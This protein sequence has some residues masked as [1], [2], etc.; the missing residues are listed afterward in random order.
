MGFSFGYLHHLIDGLG[1]N[2]EKGFSRRRYYGSL[3]REVMCLAFEGE[4]G[5]MMDL[6]KKIQRET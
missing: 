3:I 2:K 6:G 5:K 1:C 4:F